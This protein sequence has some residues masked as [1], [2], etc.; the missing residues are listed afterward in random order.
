MYSTNPAAHGLCCACVLRLTSSVYSGLE[1]G[2]WEDVFPSAGGL[3]L[4]I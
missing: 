1:L 2:L 4:D 3:L